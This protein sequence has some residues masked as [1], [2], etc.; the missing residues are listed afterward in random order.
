MAPLS[1]HV[2]MCSWVGTRDGRI[3]RLMAVPP[4]L[5]R[6]EAGASPRPNLTDVE[7][8]KLLRGANS[9]A[10][11]RG[12]AVH[13]P[14]PVTAYIFAGRLAHRLRVLPGTDSTM[15]PPLPPGCTLGLQAAL[16]PSRTPTAPPSPPNPSPSLAACA[17][18]R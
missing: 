13:A 15:L 11:E 7:A 3:K 4:G 10:G 6:F 17:R 8:E 14:L 1:L 18:A 5:Q 2:Q 12:Q 16:T 9:W